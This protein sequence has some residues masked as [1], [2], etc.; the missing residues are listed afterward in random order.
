[1]GRL[2]RGQDGV[3][4]DDQR[5]ESKY[6]EEKNGDEKDRQP[7]KDVLMAK[8][9]AARYKAQLA[10][11]TKIMNDRKDCKDHNKE[12]VENIEVFLRDAQRRANGA[13][14]VRD[15]GSRSFIPRV[16]VQ[17]A[18][19]L[20]MTDEDKEVPATPPKTK[21]TILKMQARQQ[22]AKKTAEEDAKLKRI[23]AAAR[24]DRERQEEE[25]REEEE[26]QWELGAQ[27][28]VTALQEESEVTAAQEEGPDE[29]TT[30]AVM[31]ALVDVSPEPETPKKKPTEKAKEATKSPI[32][33]ARFPTN[34][35]ESKERQRRVKLRAAVTPVTHDSSNSNSVRLPQP[36]TSSK[37]KLEASPKNKPRKATIETKRAKAAK[38]PKDKETKTA[39]TKESKASKG[40]SSKKYKS[41]KSIADRD[42]VDDETEDVTLPSDKLHNGEVSVEATEITTTTVHTEHGDDVMEEAAEI[43]T[44]EVEVQQWDGSVERTEVTETTTARSDFQSSISSMSSNKRKLT[45]SEEDGEVIVSPGGAKRVKRVQSSSIAISGDREQ[46]RKAETEVETEISEQAQAAIVVGLQDV[47]KIE[48]END[49]KSYDSL[50]EES[51][52]QEDQGAV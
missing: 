36:S 42:L 37:P 24:K 30:T 6:D 39:E 48:M 45:L 10:H 25:E 44:I 9:K 52:S 18:S 33:T 16:S 21:K 19:P 3:N 20:E 13:Q 22:K 2:P 4:K 41:E 51:S 1:M 29:E 5:S 43:A 47:E 17:G 49:E 40:K 27:H 38:E 32:S 11:L 35:P 12:H 8:R 50:F 28:E 23:R 7:A 26:R 34:E 14:A 46:Q 15:S 31:E